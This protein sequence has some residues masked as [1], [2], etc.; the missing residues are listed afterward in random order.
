VEGG[1]GLGEGIETLCD[2]CDGSGY[3]YDDCEEC[4]GTGEIGWDCSKCGGRGKVV[5]VVP[6]NASE[7]GGKQ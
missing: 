1:A 3:T 4:N 6:D 7:L 5:E 2:E